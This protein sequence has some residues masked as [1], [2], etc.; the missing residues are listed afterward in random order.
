[1]HLTEGGRDGSHPMCGG[2]SASGLPGFKN[3]NW[4]SVLVPA[5][6]PKPV[7]NRLNAE[8][9]K[10]VHL[11]EVKDRFLSQGLTQVGSTPEAMTALMKE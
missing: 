8:L 10:I 3:I 1:M 6:T 7:V 4:H 9:V 11:P 5:G 2:R